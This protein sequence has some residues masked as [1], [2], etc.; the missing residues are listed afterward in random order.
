MVGGRILQKDRFL[1]FFTVESAKTLN[2]RT[3]AHRAI[4]SRINELLIEMVII[5]T[6]IFGHDHDFKNGTGFGGGSVHRRRYN[7]AYTLQSLPSALV[8]MR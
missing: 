8:L 1:D 4:A 7:L 3:K 5:L 2:S 6:L